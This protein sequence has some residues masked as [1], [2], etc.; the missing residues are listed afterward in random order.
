VWSPRI[1]KS[2]VYFPIPRVDFLRR[3]S[4]HQTLEPLSPSAALRSGISAAL[5]FMIAYHFE[6]KQFLGG[7]REHARLFGS[8]NE[9]T[10]Q[11]DARQQQV[12]ASAST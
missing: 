12:T 1:G 7:S 6:I 4:S 3:A 5:L 2:V 10:G 9:V 11:M 8:G